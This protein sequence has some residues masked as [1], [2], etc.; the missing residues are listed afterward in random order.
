MNIRSLNLRIVSS[1]YILIIGAEPFPYSETS[2]LFLDESLAPTEVTV[3]NLEGMHRVPY[4]GLYTSLLILYRPFVVF[5]CIYP[6]QNLPQPFELGR[7]LTSLPLHH[8]SRF[9]TLHL[10]PRSTLVRPIASQ[11][12]R[13][14][15]DDSLNLLTRSVN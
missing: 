2:A 6:S 1:K 7:S 14:D 3:P 11:R 12:S 13:T 15:P 8:L 9:P 4:L 10:Q 5:I